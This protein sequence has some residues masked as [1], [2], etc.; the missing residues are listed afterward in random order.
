M[1]TTEVARDHDVLRRAVGDRKLTYLGGSYGSV[2]GQYY[3]NMFPDRFRALAIDACA[4]AGNTRQILDERINSS[5]GASKTLTEILR[6]WSP[7]LSTFRT[8][9]ISRASVPR[10]T[11]RRGRTW[12]GAPGNSASSP[13]P[14]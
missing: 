1:S 3:A 2:L 8:D 5:G 11:D 7:S 10:G 6:R 14:R 12:P 4:W 13:A 9:R